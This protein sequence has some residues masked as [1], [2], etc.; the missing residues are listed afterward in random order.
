MVRIVI[1]TAINKITQVIVVFLKIICRIRLAKT[2]LVNMN[3]DDNDN[4]FDNSNNM[5]IT[6]EALFTR[7][8]DH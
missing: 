8:I 1:A 3:N 2:V 5:R 4:H 6:T 7:E